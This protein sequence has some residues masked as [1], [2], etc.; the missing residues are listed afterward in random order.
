VQAPARGLGA[1]RG[2]MLSSFRRLFRGFAR[3]LW[4]ARGD[5]NRLLSD[6]FWTISSSS[7]VSLL[8][9]GAGIMV[10]EPG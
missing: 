6:T 2:S 3:A 7:A 10:C 1:A 5:A 4:I 9:L 8:S